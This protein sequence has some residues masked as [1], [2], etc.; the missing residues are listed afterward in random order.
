MIGTQVVASI[1]K[2]S[3]GVGTTALPTS[4]AG[5]PVRV[6]VDAAQLM[7]SA[8]QPQASSLANYD[9]T[10]YEDCI[11]GKRIDINQH[12][13]VYVVKNGLIRVLHRH[14]PMKTLLRAHKDQRVT[15]I[16]F[17]QDGDVL[18]TV[19]GPNSGKADGSTSTVV[20][21]RVFERSPEIS[22]E[23]LL[24]IRTSKFCIWR[25]VWHPFNPNQF[26]MIHSN[27][28]GRTVATLVDT[29]KITTQRHASDDHPVCECTDFLVTQNAI[30]VKST[31]G[32][33]TDLAWNTRDARHVLTTHTSGEVILWDTTQ[34]T[35]EN[36]CLV[37]K[38][39]VTLRED[40]P[41]S[42]ALF[43]PHEQVAAAA[44]L[45]EPISFL[46]CLTTCFVTGAANNSVFT[47]W[48]PFY[49]DCS[50]P[51]RAQI[52]TLQQAPSSCL[53]DVVF[54]QAPPNAAPPSSFLVVADRCEGRIWAFHCRAAWDERGAQQRPLLVGADYVVPFQ[55]LYPTYSWTVVGAPTTDISDEELQEQ[56]GLIFDTKIYAYQSKLIQ[57]LTLT[58]YMCLPPESTWTDP[59]PGITV[60]RIFPV[61]SA[62]VSDVGSVSGDNVLQYDEEYDIGD[63]DDAG[64]DNEEYEDAPDPSTLPPP[65]GLLSA[66]GPPGLPAENQNAGN[67]FSNWLGA[68]AGRPPAPAPA[69]VPPPAA[70]LPP[71]EAE[72]PPASALP[73]PVGNSSGLLSPAELTAPPSAPPAKAPQEYNKPKKSSNKGKPRDGS[74]KK[75]TTSKSPA[76]GIK[77]LKRDDGPQSPDPAPVPAVPGVAFPS[78]AAVNSPRATAPSAN[79]SASE[80]GD[81]RKIV[82]E[83]IQLMVPALSRSV[84]D[85]L[86]PVLLQTIQ[87]A[88]LESGGKAMDQNALVSGVIE[89]IDEPLRHAFTH[90]MKAVL[91][92]SIEAITGQVLTQVSQSLEKF[93]SKDSAENEKM[94]AMSAQIT[95]L[96]AMVEKLTQDV[97]TLRSSLTQKQPQQ[98]AVTP[99]PPVPND[100]E[101]LK[102]EVKALLQDKKYE[103]AFTKAVSASTTE[104]AV[105]CCSNADISEVLGDD[106]IRLSQPILICL[107]QQLGTVV[108]SSKQSDLKVELEWLQDIALSLDPKD[109]RIHMHVPRVL[110]QLANHINERLKKGDPAL[111]RPLTRLLSIIRGIR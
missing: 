103:A 17:F 45:N 81:I 102:A 77:I 21:W 26:W 49:A 16:Q 5:S 78:H 94:K 53:I 32:D 62:H 95:S 68:L 30:Q 36:G 56:G 43:L 72:A 13:V 50:E 2:S 109:K 59:T 58:S 75:A 86:T 27:E 90:N 57:C 91:V 54:G 14:T 8:A 7:Q 47:L 108:G 106:Q 69:P 52:V 33:L 22:S 20:I 92:P 1:N 41:V 6:H 60:E 46:D 88:S 65:G 48:S 93:E 44:T 83:E 28:Q 38:R 84:Q 111:K 80:S 10:A 71:Q 35:P 100:T 107:M 89:A 76:E 19:G 105:F 63:D 85:S 61:H 11:N 64:A 67:L 15:D 31:D 29:T 74:N 55:T 3:D 79:V 87:K 39:L 12:L 99:T 73:L 104:M 70:S 34:L 82:R 42:R 40:L 101:A 96:T 25:V 51:Q 23:M 110:E 66:G 4:S 98:G 24:E 97:G 18:A 37:P 9:A